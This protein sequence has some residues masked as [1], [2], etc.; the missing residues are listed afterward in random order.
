MQNPF[1]ATPQSPYAPLNPS[2]NQGTHNPESSAPYQRVEHIAR[3]DKEDGEVTSESE[4]PS[5]A[6]TQQQRNGN[7]SGAHGQ[8]IHSPVE[9][10]LRAQANSKKQKNRQQ[11]GR[12]PRS[13]PNPK[14]GKLSPNS[15][16]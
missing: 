12:A 3:S 14:N 15:K 11:Q 10:T 2:P 7:A 13:G 6:N 4:M 1:I 5:W 16:F 9:P 8:Y